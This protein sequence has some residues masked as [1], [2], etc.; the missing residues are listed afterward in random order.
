MFSGTQYNCRRTWHLWAT[1]PTIRCCGLLCGVGSIIAPE[2]PLYRLPQEFQW[3]GPL[4]QSGLCRYISV[5]LHWTLA[6]IHSLL[7]RRRMANDCH[8][9]TGQSEF[10][11]WAVCQHIQ[12][13]AN[14]VA[15]GMPQR[16]CDKQMT[17]TPAHKYR[18]MYREGDLL[19]LVAHHLSNRLLNVRVCRVYRPVSHACVLCI[20]ILSGLLSTDNVPQ[21]VVLKLYD[22]RFA[23]GL[24]KEHRINDWSSEH[25]I[26]LEGFVNSE[27]AAVFIR[28]L[29]RADYSEE[30]ESG[31]TVAENEAYLQWWCSDLF[32]TE[33]ETYRHLQPLQGQQIPRM[34]SSV[35]ISPFSTEP[36]AESKLA[37]ES[38]FLQVRGILIEQVIGSSLIQ[39][40]DFIEQEHWAQIANDAMRVPLC[41]ADRGVINEGLRPKNIIA[42][43][44]NSD[45]LYRVVMVNLTRCII[46]QSSGSAVGWE[47]A[48]TEQIK[49]GPAKTTKEETRSDFPLRSDG[50][51]KSQNSARNNAQMPF[52]RQNIS[53]ISNSASWESVYRQFRASNCSAIQGRTFQSMRSESHFLPLC[54]SHIGSKHRIWLAPHILP[55]KRSRSSTYDIDLN[56]ILVNIGFVAAGVPRYHFK[57]LKSNSRFPFNGHAGKTSV[58]S[59]LL[60]QLELHNTSLVLPLFFAGAFTTYHCYCCLLLLSFTFNYVPS[61]IIAPTPKHLSLSLSLSLSLTTHTHNSNNNNNNNNNNHIT[62]QNDN[63]PP[64]PPTPLHHPRLLSPSQHPRPRRRLA[65]RYWRRYHRVHCS[66]A[67]RDC[68]DRGVQI[69]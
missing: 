57:I 28:D 29:Q 22:R 62:R 16:K 24:R 5:L 1:I 25:E 67:R 60:T 64:L 51:R 32:T 15:G 61:A 6:T 31:W 27:Q 13:W 12:E 69:R 9:T 46:R 39:M 3:T 10:S 68:L 33:L 21:R 43:P 63:P 35:S 54:I 45:S 20:E 59:A 14:Q 17:A 8:Q 18:S 2:K 55:V 44:E 47:N 58:H 49:E 41:L 40:P 65:I 52:P 30:P 26:A 66:G 48:R 7:F 4:S 53:R 36:E 50:G 11:C 23:D 42:T 38:S 34:F 37:N 56:Q 19:Y